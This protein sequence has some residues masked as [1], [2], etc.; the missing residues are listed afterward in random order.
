MF[1]PIAAVTRFFRK[2]AGERKLLKLLNGNQ[3]S[4]VGNL[5]NNVRAEYPNH[6][7]GWH[8]AAID[9]IASEIAGMSPS[10]AY[11][12]DDAD[13][14]ITKS[15]QIAKSMVRKSFGTGKCL[16][17]LQRSKALTGLQPHVQLEP[18]SSEHPLVRLEA[19]PN[20][21]DCSWTFRYKLAMFL[22][23]A[24]EAY[25]WNVPGTGV[26]YPV[27][28]YIIPSHWVWPIHGQAGGD[29]LIEAY[30][31]RPTSTYMPTENGFYWFGGAAGKWKIPAEQMVQYF[32]PGPH[33]MVGGYSPIG[34]CSM[35][36]DCTDNID[37]SRIFK[38]QNDAFPN[39]AVVFDKD[40]DPDDIS[41]PEIERL[42]M[43]IAEKYGGV[44]RTGKPA[45]LG[46]GMSL[47]VLSATPRDMDYCEG[48][49]QMRDSLMAA[50]RTGPIIL[51]LGNETTHAAG[52]AV[53]A[54]WHTSTITPM[55][56]LF[57]Q[58]ETEHMCRQFDDDLICYWP[59]SIPEDVEFEH[60]QR[61]DM[62]DRNVLTINEARAQIGLEPMDGGDVT[63]VE[64]EAEH[65]VPKG[66]GQEPGLLPAPESDQPSNRMANIF[67]PSANG[68][69]NGSLLNG[70]KTKALADLS[71]RLLLTHG[72]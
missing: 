45:V 39:V 20:P 7:T 43:M 12:R 27:E 29:T 41:E 56:K 55:T 68:N 17:K 52:K 36:T 60:T 19:R 30:E 25:R 14:Q 63:L 67:Q 58:V 13:G 66:L 34:A 16:N 21:I 50:H 2:S 70:D 3:T 15:G 8:H 37:R 11:K 26:D 1:N 24:G 33:S 44:H 4:I 32:L 31:V 62:V 49:A 48:F 57:G 22:R 72:E 38:F 5:W 51:G 35:W 54:G 71:N 46:P 69:G 61:K 59:N 28:S 64:W 9:A 18:V 23:L 40:I 6:L 53:R 65:A 10:Y 42:Q 47:Q